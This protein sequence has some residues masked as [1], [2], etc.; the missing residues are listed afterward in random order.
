MGPAAVAYT[1]RRKQAASFTSKGDC[2]FVLLRQLVFL[3]SK[4]KHDAMKNVHVPQYL[5]AFPS[6]YQ[7]RKHFQHIYTF[8]AQ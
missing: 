1:V 5:I 6:L 3:N 7:Y 2:R 4:I 8:V